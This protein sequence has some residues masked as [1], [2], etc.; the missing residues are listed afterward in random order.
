MIKNLLRL[1]TVF[2]VFAYSLI[3]AQGICNYSQSSFGSDN[4][5]FVEFNN[6]DCADTVTNGFITSTDLHVNA[7]GTWCPSWYDFDVEVNGSVVAQNLCNIGSVDLS[8]Y[9]VDINNLTSVKISSNNNDNFPDNLTLSATLDIT[10]IVTTC[11][12]PSGVIFSNLNP[13]TA[14]VAWSSNGSEALWNIEVVNLTAGDTATGVATY[15]GVTVNPYSLSGLLP[16]TNYAV[17]I[18]A[19]CGPF[20]TTPQSDWSFEGNF[21]TPPTCAPLGSI[22]IDSVSESTVSLSWAQAGSETSWDIELINTSNIPADTFS[23]TPTNAG[24]SSNSP[25]ITGLTPSSD[26]EVIVRANCGVIDGPSAW[27]TVYSF[28]TVATCQAPVSLN[29]NFTGFDAINYTWIAVDNESMWDVEIVNLTLG[30]VA[31]GIPDDSTTTT[32]Y[33]ASGLTGSTQYAFYVRANCGGTDGVSEWLGP[34]NRTTRCDPAVTPYLN[35]VESFT[36]SVAGPVGSCWLNWPNL[37]YQYRW[38]I[39]GNGSTPSGSTGPSGAAS[40]SKYFYVEAS[41][42]P[43]GAVAP[44]TSQYIDLSNLTNP[45]LSFKYHMY[46]SNIESLNVDI[47]SNGVWYDGVYSL[48]GQQQTSSAA[49]W[50]E[51]HVNLAAYADTILVRFRAIKGNGYFGDISLDD[52]KVDEGLSCYPPTSLVTSNVLADSATLSWTENNLT[53]PA[54]GYLIEYGL[55]GF[56]QGTGSFV[57]STDTFVTLNSLIPGEGYEFYVQAICVANVDS[58]AWSGNGS[59]TTLCAA[60]AAP[61]FYDVESQVVTTQG[62]NFI[63]CWDGDNTAFSWDVDNNGSTTSGNTGPSGAY[64]GNAYY[65]VEAS[66][67]PN[68][69][70]IAK[71][72]TPEIDLSALII[73]TLEFRYHMYGGNM[74]TLHV[75]VFDTIWHNEEFSLVGQQH[76]SPT[77][78]WSLAS[79]DLSAYSGIVT[80][81]FRGIKGGGYMGDMSIDDIHVRELPNC[82]APSVDITSTGTTNVSGT[83]DSIGTFGT[84]WYIE[85]VDIT[86]GGVPTGIATD[87]TT[88]LNFSLTGLNPATEY[89]MYIQSDCGADLSDW[90]VEYFTTDCAPIGDFETSF[91]SLDAGNDTLICWDYRKSNYNNNSASVQVGSSNSLACD[92]NKYIRMYN[93]NQAWLRSY[94]ITPELNNIT[95]GTNILTFWAR[96]GSTWA[97]NSPFEVGTISN[98][99]SLNT[100]TSLYSGSVGV[101]CDSITVPFLSYTGTDTRIAIRFTPAST[102]DYLYI[103]KVKWGPGPDCAMPVGFNVLDLSDEEV[104][105]DWLNISPDSSWNLELVDVLDTL[106]VYD[107][108][109]TDTAFTHPFTI[110]GLSENTIYDVYLTNPCDTTGQAV[111]LT[112]VTPWAN[113][114]GVTSIVSP[115]TQGCNLDDSM[116]IEVTINNFGGQMQSG[117]PVELSWDDSIY[118]NVG[119]FMDTLLPGESANFVI[120]GYYDF[121][122]ALDSAFWVQTALASDSSSV[123]NNSNSSVTNLGNMYINVQVNTGQYAGEV[124][125]QVL[126]TV[127]NIN[128]YTS[129]PPSGYSNYNTYNKEVCVYAGGDYVMNAWDTYDDGWNGGTYSITRCGGIV[130]ADNGGNEVTN[131]YGGVSGSDLEVQEGFHVDECPDDDLAVMSIDG[132]SSACGLGVE[133]GTVTIMNFGNND[134]LANDAIAQYQ[135]NNSGLWIDFWDFDTGLASQTDTVFTMPGVD[136]SFAGTY[137]I[138]VQIVFA[139]DEDTTTN[140]LSVVTTSVPTLTTD[141]TTFNYDNG[142]WTSDAINGVNNSWEYGVPTTTVAGNG[143][144][145]EVWAS[146]LSGDA[147][148]NELSYLLSPCY[149]FS[150]YTEDVEIEFDFVRTNSA[151]NFRL[152]KSINGGTGWTNVWT[153]SNNTNTWTHKIRVVSGLAGESDVKFRWRYQSN[154]LNPVEGFAFDNWEVKEHIPYTDASLANLTVAGNQVSSPVS[155]DPTVFDYTYAVP[156][157]AT[158]WNVGANVNAPFYT[159]ISIDQVSTLPDTATVTVIAEDTLY[160]AVYTVYITQEPASTD[161]TLSALNVSNNAVPGFNPDT[162]CYTMTYPYGSA[163]TPSITAVA[164]H[165]NATVSILNVAIPGTAFIT[166]TAEDGITVNVYCINYEVQS[167]SSNA[168]M[169][170]IQMDAVS[171]PGFVANTYWYYVTLPNGTTAMPFMTYLTADANA[172][173][174]YSPASLPLTDTAVFEVTAQDGVTMETYY[175]VFDEAASSNANLLDLTV[176]G[177]TI[178]GFDAAVF[179]YDVELPYNSPIP[180]LDAMVEDTTATVVTVDAPSVPGTSIVTVTAADGTELVYYVNWS[181]APANDDA[182][183]DSLITNAGYFCIIVGSDTSAAMV[184]SPVDDNSYNLTVGTGF[185]SLVNLTIVPTDPNATVVISGSATVAP[186]GTIIITVTAEDGSTQEVYTINV[187]SDDCSIGLDEAILGQ[188]NV[189]PNPSNGIFFIETPAD[190]NNYTVSVVDQIGKVVYKDVVVEATMEK[191][192]DL[193]TLPAGMYN[194]RISTASDFIVKRISIIK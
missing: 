42:G 118:F 110:D 150:S 25:T 163:F 31:S 169:A 44:L 172:S 18:Q 62:N 136:M 173:V 22:S 56:A 128:V 5:N 19:D 83:I 38:N 107:S 37:N 78:P 132:L 165:P 122:A 34:F 39:D 133:V 71:L 130:I 135:F 189:S 50:M 13:T 157:G 127:N 36:N 98:A 129:G 89:A 75:D 175:V 153:A 105:L 138:E 187:V 52:I 79:V 164:N 184:L 94:L 24:L 181:Y 11:P 65:F 23:Y 190:L 16:E 1:T 57:N 73:P 166:V 51:A 120:D 154:W 170:D 69:T 142:G 74:G 125:W 43:T 76:T 6:F 86:N 111:Q 143:N 35:D 144:D 188:I 160:S 182:T 91:E 66:G 64:S 101:T 108:I 176:N 49:A 7:L 90:G 194:M 93:S 124:W 85:T 147:S 53:V 4:S 193:S 152:Q 70:A 171:L 161:A 183:L 140:Y 123:D 29:Q 177:G 72:S 149:D 167:L 179:I 2:S 180:N 104:S 46:G 115:A 178:A 60:M 9:G 61:Y 84:Q 159:S 99:D 106:D 55:A 68:F 103:D 151:H 12:P 21:T 97:P 121:S 87:T 82:F 63:N 77:A 30:E 156:F 81:R 114:L 146:N 112:F 41:S 8:T 80:I 119:T 191:V 28:T 47:F 186:Y 59:F 14:N 139:A 67:G 192:M 117:F 141:S 32:A 145:Q 40:G 88:T 109:P 148:L 174:S 185:A 162:L 137:T 155:F 15:T 126:D 48:I 58:S 17:Y 168:F 131:G 54:G 26:Y 113:N 95:A 45:A 33:M 100:F 3:S 102:F 96:N 158:N 134:V 27:T 10:Y 20:N 92:G 116:Q